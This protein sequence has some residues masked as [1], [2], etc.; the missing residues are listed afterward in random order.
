MKE[1]CPATYPSSRKRRRVQ[2]EEEEEKPKDYGFEPLLEAVHEELAPE[3]EEEDG[4]EAPDLSM[5]N[6]VFRAK[7]RHFLET[8]YKLQDN[9]I[10]QKVMSSLQKLLDDGDY[11]QDEAIAMALRER[12]YLFD[13]LFDESEE[14]EEEDEEEENEEENDQESAG[15]E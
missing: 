9:P 7:Y 2:K 4:E 10:H 8:W 15:E 13:D 12:K 1:W 5:Q 3:E 11:S 14:E 6:R